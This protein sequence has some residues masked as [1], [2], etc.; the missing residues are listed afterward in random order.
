MV[1]TVDIKAGKQDSMLSILEKRGYINSI[2]GCATVNSSKAWK[3]KLTINASQRTRYTGS[4]NDE[5][6]RWSICGH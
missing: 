5:Q 4:T 3:A 6:A 2:A 1:Q